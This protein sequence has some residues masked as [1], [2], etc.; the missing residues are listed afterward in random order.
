MSRYALA[1]A[2]ALSALLASSAAMAA[3]TTTVAAT[4]TTTVSVLVV[5]NCTITTNLPN[6]DFGTLNT[7]STT[8]GRKLI[9]APRGIPKISWS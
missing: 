1:A 9:N 6:V 5:D 8:L 4:S 2:A 3:T 7:T